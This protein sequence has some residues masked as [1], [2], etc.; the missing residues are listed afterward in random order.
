M[1]MRGPALTDR[2]RHSA[3][4]IVE[5]GTGKRVLARYPFDPK[6]LSDPPAAGKEASVHEVVPFDRA[7]RRI[8]VE[9]GGKVIAA[10]RVSR[11]APTVKV[12]SPKGR[13]RLG[14]HVRVR[15]RSHDADGGRLTYSV[16]Y[17]P[18]GSSFVP[19]AADLHKTSYR[20]DTRRLPGGHR[21]R[22]RVVATDGV[23][24]GIATS[25]AAGSLAF[26][27]P[28]V[29]IASPQRGSSFTEGDRI[30][31]VANVEDIQDQPHFPSRKIVWR[32]SL[33]GV[34]GRG[35]AI[36]AAL[37]PGT[38]RISVKATNTGGKTATA[39]RTVDVAA[40]PPI[41]DATAPGP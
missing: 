38:H 31:F 5:R 28:R 30:Q 36:S 8:V 34:I 14:R 17:S 7:S 39:T 6:A 26:K 23:R 2:P 32:S 29:S 37:K 21:A 18:G 33:Q 41:F 35:E 40:I 13:G 4:S 22:F 10:V 1:A 25:K 20:V 24:T 12:V 11:H 27:R 9:K 16:L 19:I 3:Y 15:W